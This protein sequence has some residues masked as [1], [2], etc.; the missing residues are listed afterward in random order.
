MTMIFL[1]LLVYGGYVASKRVA[2]YAKRNPMQ[3]LQ[4]AGALRK[5][6]KR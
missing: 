1:A 3:A 2:G 4:L 5:L 6:A